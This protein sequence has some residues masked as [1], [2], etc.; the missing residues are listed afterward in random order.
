[1]LLAAA[2]LP[3]LVACGSSTSGN[4]SASSETIAASVKLF[5]PCTQIPDDTVVAAGLKPATKESGIAGVHQSGWEICAWNGRTYS[6]TVYSTGR[7]V[8]EFEHKAGN[9]DF[10]DVVI[11]GRQGRQF[12][13]DGASKDLGCDVVFPAS[14]GVLQLGLLNYAGV[15]N[16]DDPCTLLTRIGASIVPVLPK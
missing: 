10:Q 6:L 3:G 14:Q 1:M 12:R 8:D 4:P 13:V 9:V 7:T 15:D 16:L 5:D 11:G 2:A